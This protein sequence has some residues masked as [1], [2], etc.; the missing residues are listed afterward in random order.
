[1]SG[2]SLDMSNRGQAVEE[3]PVAVEFQ[4]RIPLIKSPEFITTL[5]FYGRDVHAAW[6]PRYQGLLD[7]FH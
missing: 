7:H 3:P 2:L 1:M 5:S 6:K 4:V